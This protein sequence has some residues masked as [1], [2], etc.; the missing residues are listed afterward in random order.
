M[1][2]AVVSALNS[3]GASTGIQYPNTRT[4]TEYEDAPNVTSYCDMR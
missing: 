2:C 3:S 4:R 1:N